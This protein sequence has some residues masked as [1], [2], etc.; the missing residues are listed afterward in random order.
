MLTS[1]GSEEPTICFVA[2]GGKRVECGNHKFTYLSGFALAVASATPV[3]GRVIEASRER[4]FLC[5]RIEPDI[6]LMQE[7]SLSH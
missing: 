5:A 1:Q 7:S 3:K 2:Q 6:D 4:P